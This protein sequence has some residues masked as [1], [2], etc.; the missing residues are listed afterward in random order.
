LL[1]L[2]ELFATAVGLHQSGRVAEAERLYRQILQADSRHC[3][4]LHMLGVLAL[5]VGRHQAAVDLIGQAIVENKRVPAFHNNLGNALK[6]LGR[7][8]AALA[9]FSDALRCAPG[10]AGAHYNLAVTLQELG[11]T[12]EAALSY[13]R[14]LAV[15]PEHTDAQHN[16]GTL[17]AATGDWAEAAA[18]FRRA[19]ALRPRHANTLCNLGNVLTLQG[20]DGEAALLFETALSVQPTHAKSLCGLGL[21]RLRLARIEEAASFQRRAILA[22]PDFVDSYIAL[23]RALGETSH[24]KDAANAC[25]RAALLRP[26]SPEAQLSLAIASIPIAPTTE[27]ASLGAAGS[28]MTALDALEAWD[29]AYPGR[30]GGAIGSSQPFHLAYRPHD[31]TAPLIR[32]G[33]LAGAAASAFWKVPSWQRRGGAKIR[34][35]VISGH[36]RTHP[37]WDMLVK[38]IVSDL[39]REHFELFLYH[40]GSIIDAETEWARRAA[41]HFFQGPLPTRGWLEQLGEDR[42]D[43]LYY[44]EV[45]MDPVAGVLAPLRLAPLQ[46]AGWG[47]PVTTGLPTIDLFFSG[48][49]LEGS[50]ADAHYSEK[51]IRLPGTGLCTS[52]APH[53]SVRWEG[54]APEI[55]KFALC[56]QPLK[57]DPAHDRLL[58]RIAKRT[59][60]CEF[61]LAHS[62]T[63]AWASDALLSR[64]AT[65]FRAEGLDP[66]SHLRRFSWMDRAGFNGFL[67]AMDV[68]LD[69]PAFSGYTTAWQAVHRGLPIVTLEGEFLR[70]RLA[71][72]LLRQIGEMAGVCR[73]EEAYVEA[74]LGRPRRIPPETA[75]RANG[76]RAAV[77]A[78]AEALI[79]A[80]G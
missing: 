54:S 1:R 37:V 61:W 41:D 65:A 16:L 57:F 25:R 69:C 78:F 35:G 26:E 51:L 62:K 34:L 24:R 13:R 31:V 32:Y 38:G 42:P 75:S 73:T 47:H 63:H 70:Q 67:D 77:D 11:R 9:A 80:L 60:P 59:G 74:A 76:N 3:D 53:A 36:V 72:G 28:F 23:G 46:A 18:Q 50:D 52:P 20:R 21:I 17:L 45:G 19:L 5:Q 55:L 7:I 71:A 6:G 79:S 39:D 30:L 29:T 43:I 58:A 33:A 40:T 12:G 48:D 27:Q 56:Q 8:E 64:L 68:S 66:D 4:A 2:R 14:T 10:H 22:E 49:L 44:P 15:Q